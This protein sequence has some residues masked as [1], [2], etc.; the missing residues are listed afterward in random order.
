MTN[1]NRRVELSYGRARK[2]I[3]NWK[4]LKRVYGHPER[5]LQ[6]DNKCEL[7][8]FFSELEKKVKS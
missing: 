5:C 3:K 1:A 2:L 8:R 7:E 6:C 4:R